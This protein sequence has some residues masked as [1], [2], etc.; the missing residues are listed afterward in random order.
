VSVD[1][2][3]PSRSRSFGGLHG[4]LTPTALRS[5]RLIEVEES[6]NVLT[7]EAVAVEEACAEEAVGG[8]ASPD[9]SDSDQA[10]VS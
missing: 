4:S 6:D 7:V 5:G 1:V 2:M 10:D 8:G 3:R 9:N